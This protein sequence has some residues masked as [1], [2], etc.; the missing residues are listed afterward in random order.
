MHI[1]L[2]AKL[3]STFIKS[4]SCVHKFHAGCISHSICALLT[5]FVPITALA[6]VLTAVIS[7][8]ATLLLS[9]RCCGDKGPA[10]KYVYKSQNVLCKKPVSTSEQV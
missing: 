9:R 2:H 8:V 1:Q 4:L 10:S 3:L 7:S 5:V 6:I